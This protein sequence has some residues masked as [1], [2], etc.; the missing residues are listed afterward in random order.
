MKIDVI[1]VTYGEPRE[2]SFADQ[3]QYSKQIM[4]KLTRKVAPIPKFIIPA[5]SMWRGYQRVKG[6]KELGYASPLEPI[7][8][9]QARAVGEQMKA[10]A[11]RHEWRT[12][13]AYEFREPTQ[14]DI[15]SAIHAQG[16][17]VVM[18]VPMYATTGD[19]TNGITQDDF[20]A[21]QRESGIRLPQTK[22]VCFRPHLDELSDVLARYVRDECTRRGYTA[23]DKKDI[24]LLLGCHGTVTRPS[25]KIKNTGYGDTFGIYN[26]LHYRLKDEF[27]TVHIG[28]LNHVLGGEW[29]TPNAEQSVKAMLEEGVER[30]MYF[31]FGF[32]ADNAES[33][34][35]GRQVME[36]HGV[37]TY[38]HLDCVN[39]Y[40]P[41][42]EM[43]A[44]VVRDEMEGPA[45]VPRAAGTTAAA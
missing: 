37:E 24:G 23:E 18:I 6:W 36:D 9:Q 7:T 1:L 34:L 45:S 25:K 4:Y 5:W 33:Q 29:T 3:Y 28:W 26:R 35:E 15:L 44:R 10:I 19:F 38:D 11:P 40:A 32:V 30:F 2:N 14:R 21:F 8:E 41:F 43:L 31:P 13:V 27:R 42:I 16:T 12:H 20:A 17:D 22:F 39:T